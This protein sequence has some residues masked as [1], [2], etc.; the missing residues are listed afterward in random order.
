M[1]STIHPPIETDSANREAVQRLIDADP[2]LVD[3]APALE[4]RAG[5]DARH[6][7]HLGST[8]AVG[9]LLRR[10]A[11]GGDRRRAVR[12]TRARQRGGRRQAARR[13]DQA[14]A[15]VTTT[16]ASDRWP[17]STP[18]RCRC[19]SWRTPTRGN[20]AFCNFFEGPS[21]KRLNYGVYDDEVKQQPAPRRDLDRS[22]DRR[23]G[24]RGARAGSHCARSSAAPSTWAT[25][26]TAATRRPRCSSSRR[27]SRC[28]SRWPSSAP[29]RCARTYAYLSHGQYFFL[30]LSMAYAKATADA[31]RDV[32]GS[33]MVSAMCFSCREFAIRVSGLGDQWFTAPI[34]P[35]RGEAVR[36]LHARRRR[37]HGRREPDQRDRRA[38]RLRA[39][40]RVLRSRTTRAARPSR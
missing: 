4:R 28:C 20:R 1:A 30:R 10:P 19:S 29:R 37:V 34:P 8:D 17:G 18:R 3:V 26:C 21:P 31:T 9:V 12:G 40:R 27:C 22:G 32:R 7:P 16:A 13:P 39:G 5:D 35:A 24:P 33:S 23:G 25:S 6:D 38:G 2:I 14:R 15:P 11:R 36:R